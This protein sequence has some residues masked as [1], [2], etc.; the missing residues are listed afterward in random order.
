MAID[1]TCAP[2]VELG[3]CGTGKTYCL[4]RMASDFPGLVLVLDHGASVDRHDPEADVWPGAMRRGRYALADG[5]ESAAL[6]VSA[7]H[8]TVLVRPPPDEGRRPR[9][10]AYARTAERLAEL[11]CDF[12]GY[13]VLVLPDSQ[14]A[15][16]NDRPLPAGVVPLVHSYRHR[17]AGLWADTQHHRDMHTRLRNEARTFCQHGTTEGRDFE[18][19]RRLCDSHAAAEQL[20]A[21]VKEAAR[22]AAPRQD[23]GEDEPGWHVRINREVPTDE[24]QLTR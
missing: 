3:R 8:R 5:A 24:Y 17:R 9:D 15:I 18:A 12:D 13:A 23:G 16:P 2:H 20:V 21:C 10:P 19:L 22:R 6:A 1:R 11:A 7:G 4:Q 14:D